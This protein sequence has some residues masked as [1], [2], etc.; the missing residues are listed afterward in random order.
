[1]RSGILTVTGTRSLSLPAVFIGLNHFDITVLSYRRHRSLST[2]F[3][4]AS[5]RL[6][7]TRSFGASGEPDL[8]G[9]KAGKQRLLARKADFAQVRLLFIVE[10]MKDLLAD[11]SFTTLLRAEG[12][13]TMP[14]A[15]AARIAGEVRT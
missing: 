14:Q 2:F 4:G 7:S 11:E 1:M 9:L 5:G 8:L 13:A 12:L 3:P 6:T 10:A 15:L